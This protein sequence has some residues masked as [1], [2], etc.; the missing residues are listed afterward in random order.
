MEQAGRGGTDEFESLVKELDERYRKGGGVEYLNLKAT[1]LARDRPADALEACDEV[2]EREPGHWRCRVGRAECLS[3]VGRM[4]EGMEALEGVG[5][6]EGVW[7]MWLGFESDRM[8]KP[9]K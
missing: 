1:L 8:D 9:D 2:L 6:E 4:G 5:G 3:R 7:R